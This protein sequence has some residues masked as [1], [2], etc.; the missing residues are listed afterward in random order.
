MAANIEREEGREADRP[1]PPHHS[2][3]KMSDI[4]RPPSMPAQDTPIDA[5]TADEAHTT[6]PVQSATLPDLKVEQETDVKPQSSDAERETA[7]TEPP[8]G[9]GPMAMDVDVKQ[10]DTSASGIPEAN[11]ASEPFE[12]TGDSVNEPQQLQ[13]LSRAEDALVSEEHGEIADAKDREESS[14]AP[15]IET[16][17]APASEHGAPRSTSIA[18]LLAN[19]VLAKEEGPLETS[20]ANLSKPSPP[21]KDTFEVSAAMTGASTQALNELSNE[22]EVPTSQAAA[23]LPSA[24]ALTTTAAESSASGARRSSPSHPSVESQ[25]KARQ[26]EIMRLQKENE[27]MRLMWLSLPANDHITYYSD[28]EEDA[29]SSSS[30]V[31]GVRPAGTYGGMP[32]LPGHKTALGNG[33]RKRDG[34]M[35]EDERESSD[36]ADE[37]AEKDEWSEERR[38]RTGNRG[39]KLQK[40][41]RWIRRGKLGLWTEAKNEKEIHDRFT[42][43]VKAVQRAGVDSLLSNAPGPK[44]IQDSGTT[45]TDLLEGSDRMLLKNANSTLLLDENLNSTSLGPALL[46]PI[47]SARALLESHTL[48]HTFRNPHIGALS[49]TALDLRESEGQLSRALGRCF[50]AMERINAYQEIQEN[51]EVDV[52]GGKSKYNE[53]DPHSIGVEGTN[54]TSDELN[55]AFAQLDKLFITKEG[56][57][58]PMVA[59]AG[60]EEPPSEMQAILSV[61]Q[62]RDVVRAALECL[63]EL[64]SDSLEYVERLDEVRGRL[65]A[66]KRRRTQVW[67]ALRLWAIK[68][69]TGSDEEDE[70][71]GVEDVIE[72][73]R[74][75][76]KPVPATTSKRRR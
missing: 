46:R 6:P 11:E 17:D 54:Y 12:A 27:D 2:V 37:E 18:L 48:R 26:E 35:L 52:D 53:L 20:D 8:P 65:E 74:V 3:P 50:S 44:A 69:E 49:K 22:E 75:A 21:R 28:T 16:G 23:S 1:F 70:G 57:P 66:V 56:L 61:A 31:Y 19:K 30:D 9:E 67:E 45:S 7:N 10:E 13:S 76:A 42:S 14:T 33:K 4:S 15:Q 34:W 59:G 51:G 40:G 60:E 71:E 24:T 39:N 62:Q 41:S 36:S 47:L 73:T 64:G 29:S 72:D 38:H 58:I 55:P 63:H 5:M 43:R 25:D 68:R 32:F